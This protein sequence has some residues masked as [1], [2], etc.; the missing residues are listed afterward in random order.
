MRR[1]LFG[2][3]AQ[4]STV[5]GYLRLGG[6][7]GVWPDSVQAPGGTLCISGCPLVSL[8]WLSSGLRSRRAPCEERLKRGLPSSK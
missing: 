8:A 3:I 5:G 7:A 4:C 6:R 2:K 1:S